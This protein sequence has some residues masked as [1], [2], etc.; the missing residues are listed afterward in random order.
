V[1]KIDGEGVKIARPVSIDSD[2]SKTAMIIDSLGN[3]VELI[4]GLAGK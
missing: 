3:E 2:R 4:E 1:K